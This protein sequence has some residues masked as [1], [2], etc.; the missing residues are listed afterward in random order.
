MIIEIDQI[1]IRQV[2][3]QS[4]LFSY[5]KAYAKQATANLKHKTDYVKSSPIP[6]DNKLRNLTCTLLS[7]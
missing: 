2:K 6:N 7:M 5:F 4:N 3:L 1:K